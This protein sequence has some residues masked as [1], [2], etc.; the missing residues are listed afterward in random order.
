MESVSFMNGHK[1]IWYGR[2]LVRRTQQKSVIYIHIEISSYVDFNVSSE[3]DSFV[4][5]QAIVVGA[6]ALVD[7]VR[8]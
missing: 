8:G 1:L 2:S 3:T 5:G 7:G 6:L 4:G